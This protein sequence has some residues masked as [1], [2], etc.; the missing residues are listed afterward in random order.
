MKSVLRATMI[1]ALSLAAC[2]QSSATPNKEQPTAGSST[3]GMAGMSSSG[4]ASSAGTSS[5]GGANSAGMSS[6]GGA[7]S[8]Q[9]G[10][11]GDSALAFCA[12]PGGFHSCGDCPGKACKPTDVCSSQIHISGG[13]EWQ[14]CFCADGKMACCTWRLSS[15]VSCAYGEGMAPPCPEAQP[16]QGTPCGPAPM[17]CPYGCGD[18]TADAYCDGT[19]WSV[20]FVPSFPQATPCAGGSGGEGGAEP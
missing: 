10:T 12:G 3:G 17:A 16:E 15:R 19:T 7:G 4:G 9:G 5:S 6:S 18:S 1:G 14:E 8:A 13:P 20:Q 11:S 2:G